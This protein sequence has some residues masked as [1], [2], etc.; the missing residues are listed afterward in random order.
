V[1]YEG[2]DFSNKRYLVADERGSIVAVTD[3][4][5]AAIAIN[6]YD[7]Y[8]IPGASNTGRFQY[9]GQAGLAELSMYSYKA[10]IY[11]P[12]Y[13]RFLQTDP[14]RYPDG[15]GWYNYAKADP[16]NGIDPT[17]TC[18]DSIMIGNCDIVVVGH[19]SP[20]LQFDPSEEIQIINNSGLFGVSPPVQTIIDNAATASTPKKKNKPQGA[21]FFFCAAAECWRRTAAGEDYGTGMTSRSLPTSA[22]PELVEGRSAMVASR[23]PARSP[24]LARG[25]V[26]RRPDRTLRG[27]FDKLRLSGCGGFRPCPG[28]RVYAR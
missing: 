27:A 18:N 10:R 22:L 8:G 6:S 7:E 19:P 15:P 13:G 17:G 28:T 23:P 21:P 3:N 14:A 9:T 25:R 2:S 24:Q 26:S 11:S 4:T 16:V 12:S 1:W 20:P 5:G